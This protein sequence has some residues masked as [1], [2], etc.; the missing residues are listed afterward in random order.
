MINPGKVNS[1]LIII[2]NPKPIE[3]P[4]Q[5][6]T[7]CIPPI[8]IWLVVVASFW[9]VSRAL[10]NLIIPYLLSISFYYLG[11]DYDLDIQHIQLHK[12]YRRNKEPD[13]VNKM[14][15]IASKKHWYIEFNIV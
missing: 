5:P 11:I 2:D 8:K 14:S 9:R 12:V 13:Y 6:G 15:M 7:I 3:P 10:I 4:I 1:N